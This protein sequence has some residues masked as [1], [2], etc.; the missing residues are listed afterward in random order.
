MVC[1]IVLIPSGWERVNLINVRIAVGIEGLNNDVFASWVTC[2]A[3]A[4]RQAK[5][6]FV[7]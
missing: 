4:D 6:I 7:I 3:T 2:R 1:K 5:I